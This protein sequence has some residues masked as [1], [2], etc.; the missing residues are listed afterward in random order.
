[1]QWKGLKNYMDDFSLLKDKQV[2]D[3]VLWEKYLVYATAF[4]ISKKV[5][6]QL[7]VVYPQ[8]SDPNYYNNRNYTYLYLMSD[9]R[10]G[11]NFIGNID[12][13]M[14]SAYN[15][16]SNAYTA[17]HSSDSSGSGGGGGFSGGGG[18]R[19]RRRPGAAED[20][21]FRENQKYGTH[22]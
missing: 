19:W 9:T 3:L 8:M 21:K 11:D 15:A 17:A 20:R 14:K 12:N 10:F 6:E 16:A 13:M 18:G 1:M 5:I 4:G 22:S 2:P 7:K